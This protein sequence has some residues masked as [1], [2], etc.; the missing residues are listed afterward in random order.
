MAKKIIVRL[1]SAVVTILLGVLINYIALPA[2]TIRSEGLWF[3]IVAMLVIAII[4]FGIGEKFLY[5]EDDSPP[6][7]TIVCAVACAVVVVAGTICSLIGSQVFNANRYQ[8]LIEIQQG[9]FSADI[10]EVT[11]SNIPTVDVGTA[12]KLGDR[13]IGSIKNTSWYEVDDEYNLV[14]FNGKPYRLSALNYGGL[15]KYFKAKSVGIPGYVLVDAV[16]QEAKYVETEKPIVYSTSAYFGNDIKRYLRDIYPSYIFDSLFFEIDEEGNPYY[17]VSVESPQI[18]VFGGNVVTSFILVDACT[19]ECIE[20]KPEELP[21]WIDHAY[22]MNYLADVTYYNLEYIDGYFNHITSKTGIIRTTYEYKD[23]EFA[24]YNSIVSKEGVVF[25]TGLTPANDAESNVGFVTLNPKTGVI[26]RYDY[27]GAEEASAQ[28]AAEG[29]VQNLGYY[30]TF[31]NMLNVDGNPTYF[32]VLKDNAGLIQRYALCNVSNYSQV[33]ESDTLEEAVRL[34]RD[35][36]GITDA[37]ES[38]QTDT[39]EVTGTIETLYRAEIDGNTYFYYVLAD[40]NN[41]FMS[42]IKNSSKQVTLNVGDTI[43]LTYSDSSEEGVYIV[44]K[45]TF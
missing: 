23:S 44:S 43:T 7:A 30:A 29:L 10:T 3:Y 1:V 9:D 21:E 4:C 39:L 35:E 32:M 24:G 11:D 14:I 42:S 15:F 38:E 8:N 40:N 12:Q 45:I 6:I 17:I 5:Y 26:K 22:S 33:I 34:Y 18:G 41:L 31:P 27:A 36:I 25:Y 16:T 19:G 37:E 28:A 20:Y 2:W 13:T